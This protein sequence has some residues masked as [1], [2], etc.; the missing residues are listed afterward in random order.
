MADL[1]PSARITVSVLTPL[2]LGPLDYSADE[3]LEPG[4]YVVVP[5]SGRETVGIVWG[6][7]TA[8]P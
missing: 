1:F 4:T 6:P 5:V 2:P 7:G 8:G 3:P